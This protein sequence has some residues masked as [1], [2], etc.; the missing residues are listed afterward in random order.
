MNLVNVAFTKKIW[1][2]YYNPMKLTVLTKKKKS[3][4]LHKN[5][6]IQKNVAIILKLLHYYHVCL[7]D[8]YLCNLFT[9]CIL[10]EMET[11]RKAT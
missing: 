7:L 4:N 11:S 2:S 10:R 8:I 9:I 5:I 6:K 1:L 3:I